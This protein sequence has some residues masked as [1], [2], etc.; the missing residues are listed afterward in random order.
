VYAKTFLKQAQQYA[1]TNFLRMLS[2]QLKVKKCRI[3]NTSKKYPNSKA[4]KWVQRAMSKIFV[5]NLAPKK[6]LNHNFCIK[7]LKL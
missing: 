1:V 4:V 6:V 5:F 7:T 2:M 3:F